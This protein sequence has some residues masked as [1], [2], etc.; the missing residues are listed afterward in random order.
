MDGGNKNDQQMNISERDYELIQRHLSDTHTEASKTEFQ[1]KLGDE[2]FEKELLYQ[3]Q[4]IDVLGEVDYLSVKEELEKT[5]TAPTSTEAAKVSKKNPLMWLLILGMLAGLFLAGLKIGKKAKQDNYMELAEAYHVAYPVAQ[6]ERGA[7]DGQNEVVTEGMKAYA[8]NNWQL[9][10]D[11]FE[12]INPQTD[13]IRLYKSNCLIELGN[14]QKASDVLAGITTMD[15]EI[16][17]NQ[18]YYQ[19]IC[20]VGTNEKAS[21]ISLLSK[22]FPNSFRNSK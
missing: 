12:K 4:M 9:A 6:I 15:L 22:I 14:Y 10:L 7:N 8:N 1:S 11:A 19:A 21:A 2:A 20:A 17:E 3:A 16:T 18:Q 13:K 5:A